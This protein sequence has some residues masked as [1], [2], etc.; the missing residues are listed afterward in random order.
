MTRYDCWNGD[1]GRIKNLHENSLSLLVAV[2]KEIHVAVWNVVSLGGN[3]QE[4]QKETMDVRFF[5]RGS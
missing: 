4:N 5:K 2:G 3:E 1:C